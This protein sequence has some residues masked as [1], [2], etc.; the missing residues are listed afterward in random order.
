MFLMKFKTTTSS[1]VTAAGLWS[2]M[3]LV[4]Q[5][6]CLWW[7]LQNIDNILFYELLP[8]SFQFLTW[9]MTDHHPMKFLQQIII[10]NFL[11]Y[12]YSFPLK[13]HNLT[14]RTGLLTVVDWFL[15]KVRQYR[16]SICFNTYYCGQKVYWLEF[17]ITRQTQNSLRHTLPANH[18]YQCYSIMFMYGYFKCNNINMTIWNCVVYSDHEV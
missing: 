14:D 6:K 1:V 13:L 15:L 12:S 8:F 16:I 17:Y 9:H 10:N 5:P 7:M 18:S 2:S 11:D 3:L 4:L